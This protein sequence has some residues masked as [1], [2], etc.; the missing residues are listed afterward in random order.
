[1][2]LA[3]FQALLGH[4]IRSSNSVDGRDAVRS[5]LL[6]DGEMASLTALRC[7]PG[8]QFTIKVQRSWCAGR[9]GKAA[10][11]TLSILSEERRRSLLDEWVGAGG[12]T[13]SFVGAEAA[14]FLS[15]LA[16]EFAAPSHERSVCEFE[17]AALRVAEGV[18][19]FQPADLSVM[20]SQALIRRGR[21]AGLVK[22]HGDPNLILKAMV[23]REALT[24]FDTETALLFG[25]GLPALHCVAHPGEATLFERLE[26]PSTLA[27]LLKQDWQWELLADW[28]RVGVLECC[29]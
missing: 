2:A 9:A 10:H 6:S 18:T 28:L 25:P 5:V 3:D 19:S 27:E 16:G 1:M 12:G 22:F 15:F 23:Q 29:S 7:S 20:N 4:L 13:T 8:L 24:P 17:M 26:S 14:A 21:Y 11:L